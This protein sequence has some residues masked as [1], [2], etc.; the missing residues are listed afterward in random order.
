MTIVYHNTTE[1]N[2]SAILKAWRYLLN[3]MSNGLNYKDNL[4]RSYKL[5]Q[6]NARN[7]STGLTVLKILSTLREQKQQLV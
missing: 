4:Q 3:K 7:W 5:E 1:T 6:K 2:M